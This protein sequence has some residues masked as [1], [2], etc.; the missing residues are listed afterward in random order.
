MEAPP[1]RVHC[2]QVPRPDLFVLQRPPASTSALV[3]APVWPLDK[4]PVAPA[5][6]PARYAL[7]PSAGPACL[8]SE[9]PRA[10]PQVDGSIS[11]YTRRER[12]HLLVFA[13]RP[14]AQPLALAW[15]PA[16]AAQAIRP[17]TRAPYLELTP[18]LLI[19]LTVS[20][21]GC[22]SVW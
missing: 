9:S 21:F 13:C 19:H 4:H 15:P 18:C 6:R 16:A 8:P 10:L 2:A 14:R 17:G 11:L 20:S 1:H 22:A 12:L 5:P 3:L 7:L